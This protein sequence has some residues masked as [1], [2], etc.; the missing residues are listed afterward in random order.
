LGQVLTR[1]MDR[2]LEEPRLNNRETLLT[3]AKE[4]S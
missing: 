4:L 3:L 2:V 1:L